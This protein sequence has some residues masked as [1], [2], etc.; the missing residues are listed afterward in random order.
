MC[1]VRSWPV[2]AIKTFPKIA[3]LTLAHTYEF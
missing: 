2:A 1:T 3:K